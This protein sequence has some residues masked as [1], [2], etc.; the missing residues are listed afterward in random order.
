MFKRGPDC[1]EITIKEKIIF[2]ILS[3]RKWPRGWKRFWVCSQWKKD[4]WLWFTPTLR[5]KW[6]DCNLVASYELWAM[7]FC[8][9]ILFGCRNPSRDLLSIQCRLQLW[10]WLLNLDLLMLLPWSFLTRNL[11]LNMFQRTNSSLVRGQFVWKLFFFFSR[12]KRNSELQN[13][14]SFYASLMR[15][16]VR[17]CSVH[18]DIMWLQ[19]IGRNFRSHYIVTSVAN[20]AFKIE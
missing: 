5:K 9:Q 18:F 14:P 13:P 3:R 10:W 19:V 2:T 1:V 11:V 8:R 15:M 7:G 4:S 16:S 12:K 20:S 17:W 6:I